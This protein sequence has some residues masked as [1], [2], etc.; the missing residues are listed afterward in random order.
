MKNA[1]KKICQQRKGNRFLAFIETCRLLWRS[2]FSSATILDAK[3]P[4]VSMT[5]YGARIKLAYLTIESIGRGTVRPSRMILWIGHQDQQ[6]TD[7]PSL[8]RL[9][10]R[11]LEIRFC[12]NWG[13]HCKYYPYVSTTAEFDRPLVTADDDVLYPGYWLSRLTGA[14]LAQPEYIHCY[15]A[16]RVGIS[17]DQIQPYHTWQPCRT[18]QPSF[19]SFATG[20]SGV[21]YPASFLRI[22]KKA[23]KTFTECCPKADDVWLHHLAVANN[24]KIKQIH[25][26]PVHFVEAKGTRSITL[27][28][29]NVQDGGNDAQ[30]LKTYS[31]EVIAKLS[32]HSAAEVKF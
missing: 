32:Q 1:F 6:L 30:I 15:R 9:V 22:A 12:E 3:G 24:Y 28:Q 4:I 19:L 8:K 10:K 29:F 31:P 18:N 14:H 11:G 26:R 23:G 21:I 5:T 20:V 17:G 25:H 16:H 7:I 27:N 2:H 13:P